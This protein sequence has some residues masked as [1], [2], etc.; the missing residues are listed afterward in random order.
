MSPAWRNLW[1]LAT[2]LLLAMCVWFSASA[3]APSISTELR[4]TETERSWLTMSVQVGFAAGALASA[5]ANLAD[6]VSTPRLFMICGLAGAA[7]NAAIP[8]LGESLA[9]ILGMRFLTG[10]TLAGVYPVGMK[11][12]SSWF[13]Q[14]RGLAIG[15]LVGALSIGSASPH[16]MN[17]ALALGKTAA[18]NWRGVMFAA[19]AAAVI[20]ACLGG[21][22]VAMGPHGATA[23]RFD[24]RHALAIAKDRPLRLANGGYL[25][26][27]W[28]LYAM[29][30]WTPALLLESWQSEYEVEWP[31]RLAGFLTIAIGG[32]GCLLAGAWADRQGRCRVAIASLVLSGGCALVAGQL[33]GSPWILTLVCLIWGFAVVADSAQF[34]AAISELCDPRYVGTA[35]TMQTCVGFMLTSF[36]IWLLPIARERLGEGGAF[37]ILAAGPALGILC[38]G[39]LAQA[40]EAV[41]M[42]GGR[43]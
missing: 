32:L 10:A 9:P 5:L 24:W 39:K 28:E 33:R 34:S 40:P 16:L 12:M 31:G 26:H 1:R 37:S 21:L 2:A 13:R 8:I 35:L 36:S 42:A 29:W 22:G 17:L 38:M 7:C 6:R 23:Q 14:G 3:V 4:L 19:S 43:G 41:K 27:M 15:I 18:P 11:I 30:T 20:G 25:G